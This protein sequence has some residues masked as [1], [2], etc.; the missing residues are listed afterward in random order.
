MMDPD[1]I[2]QLLATYNATLMDETHPAGERLG[3]AARHLAELDPARVPREY[4]GWVET[5]LAGVAAAQAEARLE[6]AAAIA[7][8]ACRSPGVPA[9]SWRAMIPVSLALR[10]SGHSASRV[11]R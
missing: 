5:M 2:T 10:V 6:D 9:P 1:Q 7:A 11:S 3:T 4:R 8:A